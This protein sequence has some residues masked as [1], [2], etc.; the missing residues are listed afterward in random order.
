MRGIKSFMCPTMSICAVCDNADGWR[1]VQR[2]QFLKCMPYAQNTQ[3]RTEADV[4]AL[5]RLC[6]R[7]HLKR[8][9]V[10]DRW[11][12]SHEGIILC[13][14]AEMKMFAGLTPVFRKM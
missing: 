6:L 9:C 14:D 11:R 4:G 2:N 8:Q 5:K 1:N 3:M 10:G 12:A 7:G 13:G